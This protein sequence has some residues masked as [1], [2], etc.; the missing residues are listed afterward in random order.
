MTLQHA[1]LA[2]DPQPVTRSSQAPATERPRLIPEFERF[3]TWGAEVSVVRDGAI[4]KLA[5]WMT[6]YGDHHLGEQDLWQQCQ[7][8]NPQLFR[9]Y[10]IARLDVPSFFLP[11]GE[12]VFRVVVE[13]TQIPENPPE[14]VLMRHVEALEAFPQATTYLLQPVFVSDP[15]VRLFSPEELRREAEGD[16]REVMWFAR[17]FGWA[18]RSLAYSRRQLRAAGRATGRAAGKLLEMFAARLRTR[19]PLRRIELDTASYWIA[20]GTLTSLSE[21]AVEQGRD[22]E[23]LR[24]RELI[25]RLSEIDPV[26]CFELPEQPG[27]L[28]FESHWFEGVDGRR[29]VH[30]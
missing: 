9:T 29:Y 25:G 28:W 26:L 30:Y 12:V 16:R 11:R 15:A 3:G 7:Q 24:F 27:E 1:V 18:F 10:R 22:G 17:R 21:R 20:R 8:A 13:P 6:L 19:R 2:A 5:R 4:L 23:A 14:G